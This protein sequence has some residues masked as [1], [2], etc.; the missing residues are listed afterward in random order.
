MASGIMNNYR[1]GP[2]TAATLLEL[3]ATGKIDFTLIELRQLIKILSQFLEELEELRS[4][5]HE[6]ASRR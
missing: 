4:S 1:I 3:W 5:G 2:I 6:P